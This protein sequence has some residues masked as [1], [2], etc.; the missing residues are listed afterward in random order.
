MIRKFTCFTIAMVTVFLL[1]SC[2]QDYDYT[3]TGGDFGAQNGGVSQDASG[4]EAPPESAETSPHGTLTEQDARERLLEMGWDEEWLDMMG[5]GFTLVMMYNQARFGE[6]VQYIYDASPLGESGKVIASQYFGGVKFDETGTLV[7]S[8]LPAAFN[9]SESAIAIEEMRERGI[10]IREVTFSYRDVTNTINRMNDMFE[11]IRNAGASGWGTG[12]ENGITVWLDPYTAEQQE[13]FNDVLLASGFDLSMFIVVPA[14]TPEMQ[15]AREESI[16]AAVAGGNEIVL[17]SDVDISRTGIEFSLENTTTQMFTY[18]AP[19][20]L[21]RYENGN[22]LPMPNLPGTGGA[23]TLEAYMLQGGGIQQYRIGFDWR[24]GT[25]E[26]GR[27]MFIRD[28]WLGDWQPDGGRVYAIVEFEVTETTPESLPP[29][30]EREWSPP[31]EV[32]DVSNVTSTGMRI[33][34]ENTS[35]YDIDNR[36]QIIFVIPAEHTTVGEH[37]EWWEY[38]LP[39]LAFDD[40]VQ[41]EG[42]IPAGEQMEFDIYLGNLFGELPPGDYKLSLSIGGNASPPNPSGWA[43]GDGLVEFTVN[44]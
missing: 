16:R 2:T 42:F 44:P 22:W 41:G 10:I 11:D 25:L 34:I 3:P 5:D 20:D 35:P 38:H 43:L 33:T 36:T 13:I 32:V 23:W 28:G 40:I 1:A 9:D 29:A 31:L 18:G 17:V 6:Y 26:P 37:W 27:Y 7:V 14:V 12:A 21:A 24:F 30:P 4:T 19:W 39:F 15:L 8:V